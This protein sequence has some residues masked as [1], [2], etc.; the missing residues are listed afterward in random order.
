MEVDELYRIEAVV[1]KGWGD[2]VGIAEGLS[3]GVEWVEVEGWR[4]GEYEGSIHCTW[5]TGNVRSILHSLRNNSLSLNATWYGYI[6][7][8]TRSH[9]SSHAPGAFV[10]FVQH[11]FESLYHWFDKTVRD[12]IILKERQQA[13]HFVVEKMQTISVDN[14]YSPGKFMSIDDDISLH[15]TVVMLIDWLID[16]FIKHSKPSLNESAMRLK[17]ISQSDLIVAWSATLCNVTMI[18]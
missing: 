4:F 6:I 9:D 10:F 16:Y 3:E 8:S 18:V 7:D 2:Y 11:Y 1:A 15:L 12:K 17:A 5:F 13:M 14:V